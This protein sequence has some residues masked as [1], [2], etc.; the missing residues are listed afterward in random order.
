MPKKSLKM[1]LYKIS[2]YI[3]VYDKSRVRQRMEELQQQK[4]EINR[5]IL[6]KRSR[7]FDFEF[8]NKAAPQVIE[9]EEESLRALLV[10]K[11][12]MKGYIKLLAQLE[13]EGRDGGTKPV[14]KTS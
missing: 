10:A 12:K 3:P 14:Q 13:R 8:L 2:L 1:K 9:E 6:E 7:L 5:R 4:E 11:E